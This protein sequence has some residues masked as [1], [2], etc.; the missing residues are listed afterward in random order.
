MRI[1]SSTL[2]RWFVPLVYVA[3]ALLTA[4][5]QQPAAVEILL[6][7]IELPNP[8][9]LIRAWASSSLQPERRRTPGGGWTSEPG[10]ACVPLGYVRLVDQ[11][12]EELRRYETQWRVPSF[13]IGGVASF[14]MAS[15]Q[16]TSTAG[17]RCSEST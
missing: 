10:I 9:A 2:V 5:L 7:R 3:R 4:V 17:V 8:Q 16:S 15:P 14:P 11:I 12:A 13:M 1:T 6:S